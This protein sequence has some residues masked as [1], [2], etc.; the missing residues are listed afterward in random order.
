MSLDLSSWLTV[1][2]VC[3]SLGISESTLKRE[4]AAKRWQYRMRPR[5]PK[6]P[7]RVFSP[8]ELEARLAKPPTELV[9]SGPIGP[10]R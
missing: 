1:A 9:P 5:P 10:A 3:A 8:A 4:C 2:Q 6:R 7:E